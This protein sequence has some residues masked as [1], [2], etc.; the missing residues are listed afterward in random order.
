MKYILLDN[1]SAIHNRS[2]FIN[3]LKKSMFPFVLVTIISKLLKLVHEIKL[4]QSILSHVN[5]LKYNE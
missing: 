4:E 1:F 3:P 5:L 2:R